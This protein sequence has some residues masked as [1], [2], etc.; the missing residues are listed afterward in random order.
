MS[1][2]PRVW[3]WWTA[4]PPWEIMN[5]REALLNYELSLIHKAAHDEAEAIIQELVE[6]EARKPPKPFYIESMMLS[7]EV[8]AA[9]KVW[10]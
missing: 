1:A 2:Q 5:D 6:I 8:V 7:A 10:E 4:P 9:M 3:R